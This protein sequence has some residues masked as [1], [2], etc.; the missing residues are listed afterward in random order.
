MRQRQPLRRGLDEILHALVAEFGEPSHEGAERLR[1]QLPEQLA[2]FVF[3]RMAR[4][5]VER[6]QQLRQRVGL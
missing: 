3:G 1:P 5:F 6:L 4:R 2:Q